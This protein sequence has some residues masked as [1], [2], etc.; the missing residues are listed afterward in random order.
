MSSF[1]HR[2][3][4]WIRSILVIIAGKLKELRSLSGVLMAE[5]NAVNTV[6]DVCYFC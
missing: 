3:V 6:S 1:K 2:R 4:S 5:S